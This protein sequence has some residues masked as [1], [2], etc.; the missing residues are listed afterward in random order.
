[1]NKIF[2]LYACVYVYIKQQKLLYFLYLN[3][4][5]FSSCKEN[6]FILYTTGSFFVIKWNFN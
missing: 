1:M 5:V 4:S 6:I 2:Y 3:D